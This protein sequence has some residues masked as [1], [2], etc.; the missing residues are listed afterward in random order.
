M[1]EKTSKS[2]VPSYRS[3]F[4]FHFLFD[5]GVDEAQKNIFIPFSLL[6]DETPAVSFCFH[7]F[8]IKYVAIFYILA[9]Y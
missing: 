2:I 5:L 9:S 8:D 1:D 7:F 6:K 3:I 4:L